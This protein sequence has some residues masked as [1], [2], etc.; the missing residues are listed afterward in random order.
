[1]ARKKKASGDDAP[2]KDVRGSQS[3][4]DHAKFNKFKGSK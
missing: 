1:M 4:Q 2:K 3:I